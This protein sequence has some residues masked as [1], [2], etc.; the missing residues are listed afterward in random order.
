MLSS[1]VGGGGS[2]VVGVAEGKI[3]VA[4]ELME[5]GRVTGGVVVGVSR[6]GIV[7][8]CVTVGVSLFVGREGNTV[9]IKGRELTD[10]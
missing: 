8:G 5:E 4:G 10:T 2:D 3:V 9:G 6:G 7:S 1:W